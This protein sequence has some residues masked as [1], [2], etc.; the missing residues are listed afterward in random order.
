MTEAQKRVQY[1]YE[2]IVGESVN[3]TLDTVLSDFDMIIWQHSGNEE[4]ALREIEFD[5]NYV[6]RKGQ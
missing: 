5:M 4:A 2:Q 1:L 3:Y 6:M